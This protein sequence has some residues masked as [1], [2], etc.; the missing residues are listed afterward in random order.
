MLVF[1][2]TGWLI[3][4]DNDDDEKA[5]LEVLLTDSPGNFE[6][7]NIDIQ[8]VQVNRTTSTASGWESIDLDDKGVYNLL[9]LTNGLDTLLGSILLPAGTVR[10]IRLVL[11]TLNTVKVDGQTYD[12]STPSAQQSG[13]K[14]NINQTLA[15][16]ITYRLVLDFDVARSIVERGNNSY[17]LKPLIRSFVEATSGAVKGNVIP[18]DANPA[19]YALDGTDTLGTT[20]PDA[21]GFFMLRGLPAGVYTV[22]FAPVSG[23]VPKAIE[24]VGVTAGSATNLGTVT[25]EPE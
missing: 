24:D 12:L 2:A 4:C 3:S 7:V 1:A 25:I 16:G 15:E 13:L 11:G 8:D 19:I 14:I 5:R 22:S 6:E 17:L 9:D 21:E 10:Q 18:V 23:Y 20:L